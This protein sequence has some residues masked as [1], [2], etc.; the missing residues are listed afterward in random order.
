[1]PALVNSRLGELGSSGAEGTTVCSFSRKKFRNDW[2]IS[3][4]VMARRKARGT[5]VEGGG[6]ER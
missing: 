4:A 3:A 2:R 6:A 5:K 1:M